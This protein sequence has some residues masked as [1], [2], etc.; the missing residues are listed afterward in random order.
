VSFRHESAVCLLGAL[1]WVQPAFAQ[2]VGSASGSI[3]GTATDATTA[4]L[5]GVDV[6]V[7][8]AAL[9]RPRRTTTD[10]AGEYRVVALPPGEYAVSFLLD[11]FARVER[12]VRVG[13]NFT[14]T[15]DV[16]LTVANQK[17]AIVVSGRANVLDRRSAA[18]ADTFDSR[19]L[20]EIPNSRSV[21][22]VLSLTRGLFVPH[23]EVGGSNGVFSGVYS[24]YGRNSS[25][26]HTV[27]G[28]VITG[29]FGFGFTLD[30][31][32]LREAS[33]LTAGHGAE[34]PTAGIHTQ[35]VTKSG[36]NRY[37]GS[38][39]AG[40]ENRN[41]QWFNVDAGQIARVAPSGGGL[42]P[43]DAN[44]LWRYRDVSADAGGFLV[45]DRLWWYG[46]VRQQE[47]ASRLVNFPARPHETALTST[48]GKLTYRVR[49]ADTVTAYGHRT[50]N[51]QP[52]RLDPFGPPGGEL[53][54]TT[55]INET[56]DST[57]DQRNGGWV[58]KGEWNSVVNDSL[59]FEVRAGQFG[60]DER[61]MPRSSAPRFEDIDA[62]LVR[63]G[64]R[65]SQA[66]GRRNQLFGSVSHFRNGW[67]GGHHFKLGGEAMRL[68][69]TEILLSG[70][71]GNVLH[72]TSSGQPSVVLFQTPTFSQG[73]VWSYAAYLSDSWRV[74]DRLTLNVGVR[75]D[76][77]RVFLPAQEHPSGS[78]T[79]QRFAAVGNVAA[80]NVVVPR[81]AAVYDVTGTGHTLAKISYSRYRPAVNTST[82]F[83][84]NP[85]A[86]MWWAQHEW[87]DANGSGVWE[88]GEEGR[89]IGQPRGGVAVESLDPGLQLPILDE[90][91]SWLE[92]ELPGRIGIRAGVLWRHE[93]QHFAR[94]NASR[95]F[96]AFTVPVSVRDPGPDGVA[97]TTDDG[98]TFVLYDLGPD[99][100]NV[101]ANNVVRN[102]PGSSS[103]YWTWEIDA[104][105]R[106]NGRWSLGGGFTHTWN[107]DQASGY[108]QQPVRNGTYPVTP[109]DFINTGDGGRHEFTT[110][111]AKA[112]GTFIAPWDVRV[113]L[114]LRHQSG[115]PFGRTFKT[116][117][118]QVRYATL[119]VLAEPVGAQ[120]TDNLTVMDLRVE[121]RIRLMG[122]HTAAGFVD[123]FN[124][125][126][127][128]PE[129]NVVWSSGASYDRPLSIVAPRIVMLGVKFDW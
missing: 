29:L 76:R 107:R 54:D 78:P 72:V 113:S 116:S 35:F 49:T 98:Q 83:N 9:M 21:A 121:K 36:G 61:L 40:Y 10:D 4:I 30:Y 6:T 117:T 93:R 11:G 125:L 45:R 119:T 32:S 1:L 80:W 59:I 48:S 84:A 13:L 62:L 31:G 15:V 86:A 105:R 64:N 90:A 43:R 16:T 114:V 25:P 39:F 96:Q 38:V 92:R 103:D 28:I 56:V 100:S 127:A 118:S 51:H 99:Y 41:L 12:I 88:A 22:G 87:S 19:Q 74:R 7:S 124:A 71:P 79:A 24:A 60:T 53:S 17:E 101:P 111:T 5:A 47:I 110:W 34:W 63:G 44:R 46:S 115:Q 42:S 82:A 85:N 50:K 2:T 104:T 3:V 26:R 33:V 75:F 70:F 66:A 94:Q 23:V 122:G 20:A 14:A 18:V 126:N 95:P 57:L 129:E 102:V 97:G 27:E 81:L 58:W 67:F 106:T 8:G 120:R 109:N 68:L 69:L 65:D 89:R 91:G 52:F 128:N 108:L 77:Y 37:T 123:L 112:H 73:G 55:A